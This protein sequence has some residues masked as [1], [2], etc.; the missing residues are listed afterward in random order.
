MKGER[1]R[2]S[3]DDYF[4]QLAEVVSKRSTCLKRNVGAVLVKGAHIISTGYNG[5]PSG[6]KHCT[7]ESCVRKNIKSGERPELCRG[8]H[9]EINCIIQ[10]AIHGTSIE[11]NT[12]LYSTTFPCMNCLK[13]LINSGINRLVYKEGYNMENAIKQDLLRES[14]IIVQKFP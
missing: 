6:F 7:P 4:M 5:A 10:A 8:V 14:E 12:T 1:E 11:G 3:K 13:L 9:A 2:I